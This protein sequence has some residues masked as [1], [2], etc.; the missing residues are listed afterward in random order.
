MQRIIQ[1]LDGCF[2]S[3]VYKFA[4]SRKRGDENWAERF[5]IAWSRIMVIN[6]A[7][8]KDYMDGWQ[9]EFYASLNG[10][11]W[12]TQLLLNMESPTPWQHLTNIPELALPSPDLINGL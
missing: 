11:D 4:F 8:H 1:L 5:I 6:Y 2:Y 9:A 7:E 12:L 10:I 3:P